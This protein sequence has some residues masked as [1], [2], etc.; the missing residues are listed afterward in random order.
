MP[1]SV[2]PT[3]L[4]I[5]HGGLPH[6]NPSLALGLLMTTVPEVP[7]FLT[8]PHLPRRAFREHPVVQS[9]VGL[10]GLVVDPA[11]QSAHVDRVVVERDLNRLSSA[12]L[13]NNL[14]AGTLP[15]ENAAGLMEVLRV[16]TEWF[17]GIVI[18]SQIMG[19]ISLALKLTDEQDKAL[20]YD[21]MLLEALAHHLALRAA[22]LSNQ[23]AS[24]AS[25]H[26]I[27][28]DEPFLDAFGSPFFPIEWQRGVD[29]LD[30]VLAGVK[31]CRGISI[32]TI[33][34]IQREHIPATYWTPLL[35]TSADILAV[36]VYHHS[37]V[38]RE[39]APSL[40]AFL[41]RSGLLV[42]GMVPT[43]EATLAL[44]T[45]ESLAARFGHL[46]R[47]LSKAGVPQERLLQSILISTTGSLAHLSTSLAERALMLCTRLSH[48]IRTTYGLKEHPPSASAP[49]PKKEQQPA[50]EP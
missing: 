29:L 5:A 7:A 10:P 43:D 22:W 9:A 42:W 38:L 37:A 23:F 4:P 3:C 49:T 47:D 1:L 36:D 32:G 12:Y 18:R 45:T 20:I 21:P 11:N 27:C 16:P 50:N 33:G 13:T 8:W 40:P 44:E 14:A 17:E 19:P 25:E 2:Q 48:Q 26:I 24:R 28:L 35:Q 34:L 41:E 46:L 6:T 15:A 39:A 31:G 30:I